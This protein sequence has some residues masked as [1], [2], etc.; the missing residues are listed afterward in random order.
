M[1]VRIFQ[2]YPR[3]K[4]YGNDVEESLNER[5]IP[6]GFYQ[7]IPVPR[8]FLG[9]LEA[10]FKRIYRL[11]NIEELNSQCSL[12]DINVGGRRTWTGLGR[13]PF[14]AT[15]GYHLRINYLK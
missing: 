6:E 10:A 5:T 12:R 9:D 11:E 3:A 4:G 2:N 13:F 1:I 7:I 8:N 15:C 14:D